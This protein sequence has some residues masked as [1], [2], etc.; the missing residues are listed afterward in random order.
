MKKTEKNEENPKREG[1]KE[2]IQNRFK[3]IHTRYRLKATRMVHMIHDGK[4]I[5][6]ETNA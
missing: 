5:N 2:N 6:N 1:T 3:Y 4:W